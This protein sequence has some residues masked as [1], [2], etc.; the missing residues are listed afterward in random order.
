MDYAV[1]FYVSHA[2][3]FLMFFRQIMMMVM[4]MMMMMY[5]EYC[6]QDVIE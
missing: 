4:M 1:A 3:N 6:I 2:V 5:R